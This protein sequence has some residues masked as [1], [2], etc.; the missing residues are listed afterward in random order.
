MFV[1]YYSYIIESP[2]DNLIQLFQD[3]TQQKIFSKTNREMIFINKE[4]DN[5]F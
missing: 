1:I 4:P 5:V 3:I 2:I